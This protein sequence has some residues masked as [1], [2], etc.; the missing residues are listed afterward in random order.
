MYSKI[1]AIRVPKAELN[2]I[3]Q[4]TFTDAFVFKSGIA[5]IIDMDALNAIIKTIRYLNL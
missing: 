5:T 4:K 3:M 1:V 2:A